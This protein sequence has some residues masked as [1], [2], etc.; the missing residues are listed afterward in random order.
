[1]VLQTIMQSIIRA[2]HD[3]VKRDEKEVFGVKL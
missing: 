1:M 2:L 3:C